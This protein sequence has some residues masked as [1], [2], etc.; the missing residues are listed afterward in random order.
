MQSRYLGSD[1]GLNRIQE[2]ANAVSATASEQTAKAGQSVNQ[3]NEDQLERTQRLAQMQ[4]QLAQA[5]A[6]NQEPSGLSVFLQEG[7]KALVGYEQEKLKREQKKLQ[8][9]QARQISDNELRAT[10]VIESVNRDIAAGVLSPQQAEATIKERLSNLGL[11][12]RVDSATYGEEG[13]R[14]VLGK[15]Q[16]VLTQSAK[17]VR[18]ESEQ[19]AYGDL[20]TQLA[21]LEESEPGID[22]YRDA[23]LRLVNEKRP[24]LATDD[25]VKVM[26]R[27]NNTWQKRGE[28]SRTMLAEEANKLQVARVGQKRQ[29]GY[30]QLTFLTQ[31]IK[32][33]PPT[34]QA[35]GYL[36]EAENRIRKIIS[37][38][39]LSETDSFS[40]ASDLLQ[41]VQKAYADKA[42]AYTKYTTGLDNMAK[43]IQEYQRATVEYNLDKDY[44]KFKFATESAAQRY[45][46]Y[47]KAVV[48]PGEEEQQRL[49][50]ATRQQ[51]LENLR[52]EALKNQ[53][54][55]IDLGSPY[56]TLTAKQIISNPALVERL[57][58]DP[59]LKDKPEI[60]TALRLV[61]LQKE[62]EEENAKLQEWLAGQGVAFAKNNLS[63]AQNR[64]GYI[65]QMARIQAAVAAGKQ[66]SPQEQQQLEANRQIAARVPGLSEFV[67]SFS[68]QLQSNPTAK[69]DPQQ[70]MR[71]AQLTE[72]GFIGVQNAINQ[73][74]NTRKST[75][76][77]RFKE[78]EQYG[79]LNTRDKL[80]PT[81]RDSQFWTEQTERV[82]TFIQNQAAQQLAP[83]YG[84]QPNFSGSSAYSASVDE[85]GLVRVAPRQA[86][87]TIKVNG[88][89]IITPVSRG[90]FAPIT[91]QYGA[92]RS[93]GRRRHA[94]VDFGTNG[95]E[96]SVAIVP[97]I[98]YI[99]NQT[100]SD[101]SGYGGFVDIVGDNGYVYR[102]AHQGGFRVKDGQRVDAG[103]ILSLSDGSGTGDPHL[104]FEV[105]KG[106]NF[107][108]NGNY[109]PKYGHS[110]TI[111]PI[112]HLKQLTL[113]NSNVLQ[114]R[115]N[116][117]AVASYHPRQKVPLNAAV[118]SQGVALQ[119]NMVQQVGGR[120]TNASNV[121]AA[122]RPV[123]EGKLPWTIGDVN[124]VNTG[125]FDDDFG[126]A[127]LR[128]NDAY[129][130][131]L[132]KAARELKVPAVWIADIIRQEAGAKMAAN[133]P[134]NGGSNWGLFGFG[135]DSFND[136][137]FSD[138]QKMNEAQQLQLMVKYQKENG[139][140]KHLEKRGGQATILE[141]WAIMRMGVKWR[142]EALA[143]PVGFLGKK[144]NDTGKTMGQEL[145]LLG[146]HAG[147]E[148]SFPGRTNYRKQR[149]AAIDT[150]YHA[151]CRL[152]NQMLTSGSD[153]LPHSHDIA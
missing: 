41:F 129:R 12:N 46:D 32:N 137:R 21:K 38:P 16:E 86:L 11:A 147:R 102:Y 2:S 87:N 128:N 82:K 153:L 20:E 4:V 125:G 37:D 100:N 74:V 7:A 19:L 113:R 152:C 50:I 98:A 79:L 60:K 43:F 44:S 59:A 89:D 131:A 23:A 88:Q 65:E 101:G 29:E 31:Q 17:T 39:T 140:L 70:L 1:V 66:L 116:N 52:T 73:E 42:D 58:A 62:Y 115:I 10:E 126:Y 114:P 107:D 78:L 97:G 133:T 51:T 109:V 104:H 117:R 28:Q 26:T 112:D 143:N 55:S 99:R 22:R 49:D 64:A 30:M 94:G 5:R 25:L 118:M 141:F 121:Y 35:A 90:A 119:A 122:V 123:R 111:D 150:D 24:Y 108:S 135:R 48:A 61:G 105:H 95:N 92:P 144:L 8:E 3:F 33:L 145:E 77:N 45:G 91:S 110:N 27:V 84:Q 9:A 93:G 68:Q 134:H 81:E 96:M 69:L 67:S 106:V 14:R 124:S 120:M 54:L 136:V 85:R 56:I 138:I 47:R 103:T 149:N 34:E 80:T 63:I 75:I 146:Q 57:Q 76:Y 40:I 130:S 36:K 151:S 53:G 139:W 72:Q 127:P 71:A 132:H 142:K 148:Y 15:Q 13:S 83:V 6:N 18:T